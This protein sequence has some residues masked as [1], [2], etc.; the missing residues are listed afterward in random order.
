MGAETATGGGDGAEWA[1]R[2]EQRLQ[3]TLPDA[4]IVATPLPLCPDLQLYLISPANMQ[5]P[6][7]SDEIRLIL[8]NT[9]YWI[10]CWAGG[11]A[12]ASYI[13][14]QPA[15]VAG[16]CVVDFGAGSG[17]VAIAAKRA[18]ARR[19]IACD[20]DPDALAA[21]AANAALNQVE[22]E[23]GTTLE[24]LGETVDLIIAADVLY[25]R[26]NFHHL[27]EFLERALAVL[28]ADSRVKTISVAPYRKVAELT[29]TTL[30][31]LED[32]PEHRQIG[33]YRAGP[34]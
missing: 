13:L 24:G 20:I 7:S 15:L 12:L 34:D 32:A 29:A 22:L 5:R 19:V 1:E 21:I 9:P 4:R 31:D 2:L 23:T 10:F 33:I 30:P 6:F 11:Q 17:V 16:K 8:N 14:Q 18:G 27:H 25:D 28:V 3:R 26:D